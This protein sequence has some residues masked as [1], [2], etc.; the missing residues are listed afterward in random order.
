MQVVTI[1]T[2]HT[3]QILV[4]SCP[5]SAMCPARSAGTGR[6][7]HMAET[8]RG[9]LQPGEQIYVTVYRLVAFCEMVGCNSNAASIV[10]TMTSTK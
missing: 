6:S 2:A 9:H 5:D 4:L 3:G 7:K 1:S 10:C 8:A